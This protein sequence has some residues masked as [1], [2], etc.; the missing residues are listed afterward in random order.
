MALGR[1]YAEKG[2]ALR[3]E[4]ALRHASWLDLH[5][6]DA[7]R[8]IALIRLRQNRLDDAFRTQQRAIA[9]QP[10]EPRQYIL[11]SEI[12]KKMGCDEKARAALAQ[13]SRLRAL[14][15]NQ[16]VVN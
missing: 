13:V 8:D 14:S 9:R 1:L 2:D 6:A 5:D 15:G 16:T 12:L 11:L 10:D 3:A 4:T 7:L